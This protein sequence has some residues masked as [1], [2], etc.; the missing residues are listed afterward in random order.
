[1]AKIFSNVIETHHRNIFKGMA[2][3]QHRQNVSQSNALDYTHT[4]KKKNITWTWT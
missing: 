2:Q 4:K 1:M 3:R